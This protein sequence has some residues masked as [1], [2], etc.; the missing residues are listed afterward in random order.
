MQKQTLKQLL[1]RYGFKKDSLQKI[2]DN[3]YRQLDSEDWKTRKE[4]GQLVLSL[5]KEI[6]AM[7]RNLQQKAVRPPRSP[8]RAAAKAKVLKMGDLRITGS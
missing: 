3:A 7:E 4:A 6:V 5:A 2:H 8:A 1:A